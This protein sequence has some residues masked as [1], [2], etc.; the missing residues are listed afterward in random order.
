MVILTAIPF[1]HA[2]SSQTG[3]AN[4]MASADARQAASHQLRRLMETNGVHDRA[5]Q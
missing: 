3:T 1:A 2:V 5:G 4:Q